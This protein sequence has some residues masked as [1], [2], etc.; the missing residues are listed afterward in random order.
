MLW[1]KK[2]ARKVDVSW[3]DFTMVESDSWQGPE[4]KEGGS[5]VDI[6]GRRFR[7]RKQYV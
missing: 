3:R 5:Q 1:G 6:W 4:E 7:Q 2:Q